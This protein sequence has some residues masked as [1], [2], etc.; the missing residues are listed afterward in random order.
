MANRD[1]VAFKRPSLV[2]GEGMVVSLR[3]IGVDK[4]KM[5]TLFDLEKGFK[6]FEGEEMPT[7]V[8]GRVSEENNRSVLGSWMNRD[9]VK[10]CRFLDKPTEGFEGEILLLLRIMEERKNFKGVVAGKIMKV[11]KVSKSE[12]ELKKLECLVNYCGTG[13][14]A[15]LL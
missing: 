14:S 4:R 10:L 11:Q 13:K 2:N 1:L 9:F 12:K 6:E 8:V 3:I 7:E 15:G 5:K